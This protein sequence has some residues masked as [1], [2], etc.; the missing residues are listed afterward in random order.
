MD[1]KLFR[2]ELEEL[3]AR[4]GFQVIEP[5]EVE[6]AGAIKEEHYIHPNVEMRGLEMF[7]AVREVQPV[8]LKIN[9]EAIKAGP[10]RHSSNDR[11]RLHPDLLQG[12]QN[13]LFS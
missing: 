10:W 2:K 12:H 9:I 3:A 8:H 7:R 11:C 13:A 1:M 6:L 5:V 4:Y